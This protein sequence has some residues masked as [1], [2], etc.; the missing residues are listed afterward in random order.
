ML[1]AMGAE[2]HRIFWETLRDM[3]EA[4]QFPEEWNQ[5]VAMLAMKAGEDPKDLG[6]RRDLWVQCH[7]YK[8][9]MRMITRGYD[10]VGERVV[11][12]SQAGF[13]KGMNAPGQTL[14]AR[15]QAEQA[16]ME[17]GMCVRGYID[18]Q[19]FFPAVV[20]E[21]Q[22]ACEKW[23]GVPPPIT[24]VMKALRTELWGRYET[25]YGLSRRFPINQ[26]TGQGCISSPARSKLILAVMQ[27]AVSKLCTGYTFT[28]WGRAVPTLMFA[29][30]TMLLGTNVADMQVALECVWLVSKITG[31][32]LMVKKKTKTAWSAVV[33]ED[34]VEKDVEGWTMRFPDGEIIP[35]LT[36]METYKYLGTPMRCGFAAGDGQTEMRRKCVAQCKKAV[37]LIGNMQHLT[38][39]Q[40]AGAMD[41]AIGGTVGYYGRSTVIRRVDA[42]EIETVRIATLRAR[43]YLGAET[44][45]AYDDHGA[46]HRH[47]YTHAAAALV[48]Q[49]D[50]AMAGGQGE[51]ARVAVESAMAATLMRLGC[52]TDDPVGWEPTW[53]ADELS[54]LLYTS[55]SPRD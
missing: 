18:I 43:G 2:M 24:E 27:R 53:L 13:T 39:D 16:M 12:G 9:L 1:R 42:E 52:R 11:P 20:H 36:E 48:D 38:V 23:A 29:D 25:A 19:T 6:R 35:Q 33:W 10:E 47:T 55:P 15:L 8:C 54:C 44:A 26:G 30:D 32:R 37:W 49:I 50:R 5:W 41:A 40:M 45:Q 31:N 3:V 46:R 17:Q 51:P 7:A 21:V 28:T 4:Q 34:G 22:W 14:A